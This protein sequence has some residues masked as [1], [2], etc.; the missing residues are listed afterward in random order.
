[1]EILNNF[2]MTK[3]HVVTTQ[4]IQQHMIK[5]I[6]DENYEYIQKDNHQK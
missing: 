2:K 4:T 6:S 1:M 5:S 3:I